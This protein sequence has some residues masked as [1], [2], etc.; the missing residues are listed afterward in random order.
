ERIEDERLVRVRCVNHE[1]GPVVEIHVHRADANALHRY[2]RAE[3]ERDAFVGLD[4]EYDSVRFDTR[5]SLAREELV[6]VDA[7]LGRALGRVFWEP[8][9]GAYVERDPFPAPV[10]DP[11]LQ[12]D[13][14]LGARVGRHAPLLAIPRHGPALDEAPRVLAPHS[15]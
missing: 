11:H 6:G 5:Q 12:R 10:V 15:A 14:R 1:G 4:A 7:E 2:L 8:L 13:V 9:A 3:P